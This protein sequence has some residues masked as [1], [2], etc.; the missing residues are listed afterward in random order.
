[1]VYQSNIYSPSLFLAWSQLSMSF[2]MLFAKSRRMSTV[3]DYYLSNTKK[4]IKINYGR[5][6]ILQFYRVENTFRVQPHLLINGDVATKQKQKQKLRICLPTQIYNSIQYLPD[7]SARFLSLT[8]RIIRTLHYINNNTY[9]SVYAHQRTN[10][11]IC[12]SKI[13]QPFN[14][15]QPRNKQEQP[16]LNMNLK[17]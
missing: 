4:N 15:L 3:S 12:T 11:S 7:K 2:S 17:H 8:I 14:P 1:M 6:G 5:R 16:S 10:I 9:I 13:K